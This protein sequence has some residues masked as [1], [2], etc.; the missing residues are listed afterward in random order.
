MNQIVNI[1][2]DSSKAYLIVIGQYRIYSS[3]TRFVKKFAF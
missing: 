1:Q 3:L 2:M